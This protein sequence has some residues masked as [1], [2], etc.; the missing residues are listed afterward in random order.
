MPKLKENSRKVAK[1]GKVNLYIMCYILLE[2]KPNIL[3]MTPKTTVKVASFM[4]RWKGLKK[5]EIETQAKP[6]FTSSPLK[7]IG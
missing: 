2:E 4:I 7:A 1:K 5:T 6:N 3:L